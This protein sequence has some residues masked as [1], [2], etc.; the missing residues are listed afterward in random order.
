MGVLERPGA[1]TPEPGFLE[2]KPMSTNAIPRQESDGSTELDDRDV[3]A[4]TE[5]MTVLDEGGDVYTVVGENG[6]GEYQVDSRKGRC[7]C[8]DHQ[9]RAARCKHIRRVAFATGEEA[10]PAWVDRDSVDSQLGEHVDGEVRF[11]AADGGITVADDDGEIL[12]DS[13]EAD[14]TERPDDCE[15][16]RFDTEG[17]DLPCWACYREG[18]ETVADGAEVL[19]EEGG[20]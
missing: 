1:G 18:F 16:R 10:I 12:D 14:S 2:R 8:P 6:G 19:G 15:C 17:V 11:A 4:L 7:T 20:R 9:H 5:Y 3:R 13:E